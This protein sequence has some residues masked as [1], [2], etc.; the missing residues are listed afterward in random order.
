MRYA[1]LQS[2]GELM[3]LS[4]TTKPGKW[5]SSPQAD[6]LL[7]RPKS[8]YGHTRLSELPRAGVESVSAVHDRLDRDLVWFFPG[9]LYMLV[10]VGRSLFALY[11]GECGQPVTVVTHRA[12]Q[13][14]LTIPGSDGLRNP[15][16]FTVQ[17][18]RPEFATGFEA[19]L[20][21]SIFRTSKKSWTAT[22]ETLSVLD[23]FTRDVT[24]PHISL[25][26]VL[27]NDGHRRFSVSVS[28]TQNLTLG[29]AYA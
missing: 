21:S 17:G 27:P 19:F 16:L 25:R 15:W 4:W 10:P 28:D 14:I 29:A 13:P 5:E 12:D 2:N 3:D 11:E 22:V 7:I 8:P 24:L 23:P 18:I 20:E 6:A 26:V 1:Q 9:L